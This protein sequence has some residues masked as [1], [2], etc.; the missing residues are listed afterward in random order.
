MFC[1]LLIDNYL[2]I[3]SKTV[4]RKISSEATESSTPLG[5]VDM[6]CIHA[7]SIMVYTSC[8]IRR[9]KKAGRRQ[10]PQVNIVN[11]EN[12][13]EINSGYESLSSNQPNESTAY[14]TIAS[15]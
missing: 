2:F 9:R 1:T 10:S 5:N 6:L 8:I 4:Q 12:T 14:T 15:T 3:I 11:R 7:K 13:M